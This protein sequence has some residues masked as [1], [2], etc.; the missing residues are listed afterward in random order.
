MS[1]KS[2]NQINFLLWRTKMKTPQFMIFI[3]FLMII[4]S[5]CTEKTSSDNL[6][7]LPTTDIATDNNSPG[8]NTKEQSST[9]HSISTTTPKT[10]L[11]NNEIKTSLDD[12]KNTH[13]I[14]YMNPLNPEVLDI[15]FKDK[16][17]VLK[18][19]G[20]HYSV[21]DIYF[22]KIYTYPHKEY[23]NIELAYDGQD[24][25]TAIRINDNKNQYISSPSMRLKEDID[26]DGTIENVILYEGIGFPSRLVVYKPY[27]REVLFNKIVQDKFSSIQAIQLDEG[28]LEILA[29]S[30]SDYK[31]F[32]SNKGNNIN[33]PKS[34]H[35][36]EIKYSLHNDKAVINLGNLRIEC[37]LTPILKKIIDINSSNEK[38][39]LFNKHSFLN[40]KK[41]EDKKDYFELVSSIGLYISD[42]GYIDDTL[43][44]RYSQVAQVIESFRYD[45]GLWYKTDEKII[46]RYTKLLE[47]D[48]KLNNTWEMGFGDIVLSRGI[49]DFIKKGLVDEISDPISLRCTINN[50]NIN[51][52]NYMICDIG[53]ISPQN[54]TNQGLK[55]GDS[56]KRV[57]EIYGI[58]NIRVNNDSEWTYYLYRS[59]DT[60]EWYNN[61][62]IPLCD[63][64]MT[65]S[66]KEDGTVK[67]ISMSAYI[68][69]D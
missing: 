45:K 18:E 34:Q 15:F 46:E 19:M 56:S 27:S 25:L 8:S 16:N 50:L 53:A 20:S 42:V 41:S 22:G 3:C 31:I 30:D 59:I 12:N 64:Y 6:K 57:L 36:E 29:R 4:L 2:H 33:P 44:S 61:G 26:K 66:F 10:E 58:P 38:R 32:E 13:A 55:V 43:D 39:P 69:I 47:S 35:K 52:N 9:T 1:I 24:D 23:E 65:I 7:P 21:S 40:I 5:S 28:D 51:V 62:Y 11:N 14:D 37:Y 17:Q 63:D 49:H 68:P 54:V 67:E 48:I 60:K